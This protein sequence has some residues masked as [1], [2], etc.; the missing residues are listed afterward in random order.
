M[1]IFNRRLFLLFFIGLERVAEELMGRR[2]WKQYQESLMRTHLNSDQFVASIEDNS[3]ELKK[4]LDN[5]H[6]DFIDILPQAAA[7]DNFNLEENHRKDSRNI[8]LKE[9]QQQQKAT[10]DEQIKITT[11]P[12]HIKIEAD[13][14][15]DK[16]GNKF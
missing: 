12:H 4:E 2:K 7:A 16:T 10:E 15:K 1:F 5:F 13:T 14:F 9:Q 8:T 3:I 11:T 6:R